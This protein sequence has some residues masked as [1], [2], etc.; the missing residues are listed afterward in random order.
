MKILILFMVLVPSIAMAQYKGTY[1]THKVRQI[2]FLCYNSLMEHRP[3]IPWN[4]HAHTCDCYVDKLRIQYTWE[5]FDQFDPEIQYRETFRMTTECLQI[6]P[7]I[8]ERYG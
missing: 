4:D 1:E 2:W 8:G 5:E 6:K 3:D 7:S